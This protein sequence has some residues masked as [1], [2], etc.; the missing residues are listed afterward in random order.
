METDKF[1][2]NFIARQLYAQFL[3]EGISIALSIMSPIWNGSQN[4]AYSLA[5]EAAGVLERIDM[6]SNDYISGNAEKEE[7]FLE[8]F[9]DNIRDL[10]ND[11][12]Y[13]NN[14]NIQEFCNKYELLIKEKFVL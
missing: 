12:R 11:N 7:K 4:K 5:V 3:N 13:S 9:T 2:S 10:R 14:T 8:Y 1:I 6:W